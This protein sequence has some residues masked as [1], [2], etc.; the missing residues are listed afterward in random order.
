MMAVDGGG[1]IAALCA[2][3]G[4]TIGGYPGAIIGAIVGTLIEKN[5]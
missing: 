3:V 1:W 2:S 4:Y 5:I